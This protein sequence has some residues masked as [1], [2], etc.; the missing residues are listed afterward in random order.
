MAQQM[1]RAAVKI[2]DKRQDKIWDIPCHRHCDAFLILKEFGYTRE[3]YE[4]LEQGFLDANDVFYNRTDARK[5]AIE[6]GQIKASEYSELYSED[7][8]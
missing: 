3:D 1:V 2:K 7:L 8:W 4:I 6:S 5:N